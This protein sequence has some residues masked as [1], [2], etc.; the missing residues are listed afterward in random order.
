MGDP[1]SDWPQ[2]TGFR[3]FSGWG[4]RQLE[5]SRNIVF[6]SHSALHFS[7]VNLFFGVNRCLRERKTCRRGGICDN[8][9]LI[10]MGMNK[11]AF[12]EA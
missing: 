3:E 5:N 1:V 6:I 12:D 8:A 4:T 10:G 11:E 7:V 2:G 9:V